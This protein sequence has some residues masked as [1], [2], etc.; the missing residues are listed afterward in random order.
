MQPSGCP[1]VEISETGCCKCPSSD[2]FSKHRAKRGMYV[3]AGKRFS[4]VLYIPYSAFLHKVPLWTNC[5]SFPACIAWLRKSEFLSAA[6]NPYC[7]K[8][9]CLGI[10]ESRNSASLPWHT[11]PLFARMTKRH[12]SLLQQSRSEISAHRGQDGLP[13]LPNSRK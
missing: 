9:R 10:I 5:L 7:V 1:C 11:F 2:A 4:R 12:S 3:R 13:H 6:V 8:R